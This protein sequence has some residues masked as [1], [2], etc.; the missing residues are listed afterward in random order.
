MASV[1]F[2]GA[3][4]VVTGS[5]SRLTWGAHSAL[6]DCGLYQGEEELEER[7]F[8]PFPFPARDL[9]GVVVTHAHLDHTGLLPRLAAEGFSGPIYC[10]KS[11]RGLISLVLLDAARLQEEEVRYA[12]RKGYSRHPNPRPLYTVEDARRVLKL[13]RPIPFDEEHELFSGVRFRYRR[14]GHLLGAASVEITA[15]GSDG[16][17]R[18]WCFSGDI[19]RYGVPILK[20]PE[21]PLNAPA[22][23]LLESTYGDR[24][25]VE[26]DAAEALGRIIEETF[27]R[28]GV[29]VIPA[30]ALG[31]T[32]EVLY[33]LSA[34]A[35][36]GRVDPRRVFLDSP[37]GI[38]ATDIYDRAE[39]EHDEEMEALGQSA[40]DPLAPGRFERVR[41]GEQSK[42]L[43]AIQEPMIIVAGSGMANGGRVVHHLLHRLSNPRNS[44]IF[45]GYQAAGTRGRALVDGTDIVAIHGQTVRV[46]AQIHQLHGL[47]AHADRDELLRWCQALPGVPER[48]F[49]NHGEDPARKALSV[50]VSEMG[51]MGWP[52]PVLPKTG[53]SVPW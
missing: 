19:G 2:H 45:V 51:E 40:S 7:N 39:A 24:L 3:C 14:A 35:D 10:T 13:L 49:L 44:I 50:A 6:V 52:R 25:H 53:D 30:F 34:L 1:T 38:D 18:T 47:S 41:T 36:R 37:M 42:G 16:E 26:Q 11:S 29:V 4:G 33:H 28:G 20:D 31:R 5:C 43:N 23:V 27:G 17:R 46:R 21:P 8:A 48:V 32:Q 12:I 15:K 22:A 9:G